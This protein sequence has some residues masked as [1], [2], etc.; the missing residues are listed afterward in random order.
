[1]PNPFVA[2]TA[3]RMS[4]ARSGLARVGVFDVSGRRVRT[5]VNGYQV[6]GRGS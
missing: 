3:V 2:S 4:L 1:M 6:A 5:L